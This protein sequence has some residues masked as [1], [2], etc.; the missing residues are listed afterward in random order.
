[1]ALRSRTKDIL[2]MIPSP[3]LLLALTLVGLRYD[4]SR[5]SDEQLAFKAS[6]VDLVDQMRLSLAS[7]SGAE[8][9]AVLAVTDQDSQTFADQA[10][11]A[12]AEVDGGRRKLA[13]LLQT[14]GTQGQRDFLAQFSE[15]F[16]ELQRIDHDVLGLAVKNT[17]LKAYGLTYG[18][19]A[20]ALAE[21][22]AALS[23]LVTKSADLPEA[24]RGA[25]LACGARTGALHLQT[26]LPPHIAEEDDKKMDE[27]EAVMAREVRAVRADL[28]GLRALPK[29]GGDPDVAVAEAAFARYGDLR[30]RILALSRENTNVRSLSISLNE[31][32]KALAL[33]QAALANLRQAIQEEPGAGMTAERPPSP[34]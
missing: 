15:S 10:R 33:C 23:R 12:T 20:A 31:K 24:R 34:R 21:M 2:W 11:R 13:T 16:V 18:P 3:V 17:N 8:K 14:R 25:L 29:V 5:T 27:L 9:S 7:A 22:E 19:A 30:L 4:R 1:M 6:R 26:L 28:A 32:R